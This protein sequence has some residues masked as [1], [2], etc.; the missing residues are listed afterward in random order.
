M[1][2]RIAK[3][4]V[5]GAA[6]LL[7]TAAPAL[8]HSEDG[9]IDNAKATHGH[10]LHHQHGGQEGHID[11]DNHGA[12]LVGK[13]QLSRVVEGKIAD[14]AVFGDHAYL[15]AWGGATCKDNGVHVVDISDVRNPVEVA[16]MPSKEGSY[17]GEGMHVIELTTRSFTGKVLV[18]NNETCKEPAGFGGMNLYDVTDPARPTPLA[19]GVGD[20]TD[21]GNQKKSANQIHSVFAW[22]VGDKA[23]AVMVD[24]EEAADVDIM[25]IT[26]PKK[27]VLIAEHDLAAMFPR[28]LQPGRHLDEVFLHDM[29]VKQIGGRQVMLLSYWDG[30]YVQLDVTDPRKPS[31]LS[32]S[33]F[34]ELDP[35]A[36]VSG[37][38]VRP[39]G[40]AHQAEFTMDNRFVLAADE[41]FSPYAL[42]TR[43][44]DDRSDIAAGQG[45]GTPPLEEGQTI[46]GGSV[47]AGRACNGDTTV[48]P[49]A[50]GTQ[51]A[52]VER[53]LCTFTEKV[54]NVE[55]AGG[56][57]AVLVFNRTAS[58]GCN[59]SLGMSVEGGIPTF[60]VAPREQGFAIFGA[61]YDDA[62][63]LA[64]DGTQLA[65][66]D[67]GTPGDTLTFSSYFDGW[68]YVH[69]FDAASMAEMDTYAVPEAHDPEH[70]TGSGD[71]SVHEVAVSQQ[72]PNLAYLS[73]Y[74]AGLRI[75]DIGSGE[76]QE[77]GAF[78][79]EGGNNFWGVEVFEQDD[80]EYVA[81]SDRDFGLYILKKTP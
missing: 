51:I 11:V 37:L 17:P 69:L 48:P 25:D 58:D 45:G 28:I 81:L 30:G 20:S 53:G 46:T 64:G 63:C 3:A 54:A 52:V 50:D 59:S 21:G 6:G 39:E 56:Y 1:T 42:I 10:D 23:Y 49:A 38:A 24:N 71:L 57:E 61:Q 34:A 8:A 32:D 68:G 36:A 55:A 13:L 16:F 2:T 4:A 67:V 66:I 80:V 15:A 76:I 70:A 7:L 41:D 40:N 43:N 47:F 26:D 62:A 33:D 9:A 73:Y 74:A 31:Y 78:I 12:E 29:V 77:V 5:L 18:S 75:V 65:P 27:P 79:D 14:V 72:D 60:G 22:D 44:V 35:E 19:V